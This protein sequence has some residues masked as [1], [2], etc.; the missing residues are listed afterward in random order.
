M[1]I[2]IT[3]DP[4]ALPRGVSQQLVATGV[5]DD[6][7]RDDI[8]TNT[9][10]TVEGSSLMV[11]PT[12][13]ARAVDIGEATVTAKLGRVSGSAVAS[14]GPPAPQRVAFNLEDFR[15]A[16]LQS[17]RLHAQLILT[18]GSTQDATANATYNTDNQIVAA[19]T[20]PGKIDAGSQAGTATITAAIDG[21][22]PGTI[23]VTVEP[24]DCHPVINEFQTAGN[25][26]QDD[27][28]IEILNP[29][30]TPIDVTGWRL[31]YRASMNT[32]AQDM[33][34]LGGP[35]EPGKIRLLAG[36]GF[37]GSDDG[38]WANGIMARDS[39]GIAIL[40][41]AVVIDRVAYGS[42]A[43]NHPFIETTPTATMAA[44]RSAQRLPFDGRDDGNNATDFMLLTT[45]T[46]RAPN[47]P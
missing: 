46:P 29:C 43:Q 31:V 22:L 25:T 19:V 4:L 12:G 40:D 35:L 21:A 39:G 44:G 36:P 9:E 2:E 16:R 6:G 10:F 18:D 11:T 30:T 41:N 15:I 26:N 24:R 33:V 1:S 45:T 14:V 32:G 8:T 38:G 28:W 27:E 5:F 3:P 34:A 13:L 37:T 7:S 42:V 20:T 17:V 23:K 47:A